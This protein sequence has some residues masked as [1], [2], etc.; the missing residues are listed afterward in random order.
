MPILEAHLVFI[1]VLA[2]LY[3]ISLVFVPP[4]TWVGILVP[5]FV[6]FML[7]FILEMRFLFSRSDMEV[8]R[9]YLPRFVQRVIEKVLG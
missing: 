6:L 2:V 4:M 7:F 5:F 3:A 9:T 8:V 1:G